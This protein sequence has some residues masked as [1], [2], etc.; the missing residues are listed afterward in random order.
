M[1]ENAFPE[2]LMD[3][4]SDFQTLGPEYFKARRISER[5]MQDFQDEFFKPLLDKFSDEFSIELW[6][7]VQYN[8]IND[9][10]SNIQSEIWQTVEQIV[11]AI[12]GGEQWVLQKYVLGPK[13]NCEKIRETIAK[14][15][16]KE[17]QDER[18][19]DLEEQVK[20]LKETV[21]VYQRRY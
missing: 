3:E 15:I 14:L 13:Y 12:L 5:L 19:K 18:I 11:K 2:D 21:E 6:N 1:T 9:S 10:E 7:K 4:T 8:L 17:L 16:P 20:R